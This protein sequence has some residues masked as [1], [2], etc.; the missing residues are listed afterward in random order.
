VFN[1]CWGPGNHY[2][3]QWERREQWNTPKFR[4]YSRLLQEK[5]RAAVTAPNMNP[6]RAHGQLKRIGYLGVFNIENVVID[7]ARTNFDFAGAYARRR[8]NG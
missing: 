1:N 8:R 7:D 5:N 6:D 2:H 3:H 4:E